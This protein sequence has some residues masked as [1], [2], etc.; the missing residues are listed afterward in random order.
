[1]KRTIIFVI[2]IS[3]LSFIISSAS[4]YT[5]V[6]DF[7]QWI[8]LEGDRTT[9]IS[10]ALET[11]NRASSLI[12]EPPK[13]TMPAKLP[14]YN[15]SLMDAG[16]SLEIAAGLRFTGFGLGLASLALSQ[17]SDETALEL[18]NI[19]RYGSVALLT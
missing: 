5:S 18:S 16:R 2:T 3:A 17:S 13:D 19:L 1:M 15:K 11:S 4:G 9:N 12:A 14:A 8:L 10:F 6:Q 7:E